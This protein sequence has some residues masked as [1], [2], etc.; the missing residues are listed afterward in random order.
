MTLRYWN[1][2]PLKVLKHFEPKIYRFWTISSLYVWI[3]SWIDLNNL[4]KKIRHF[5][6]ENFLIH[7][8]QSMFHEGR[9]I[10]Q[11]PH[12]VYYSLIT[13]VRRQFA[14]IMSKIIFSQKVILRCLA[15]SKICP[16][17]FLKLKWIYLPDNK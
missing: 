5:L 2:F 7:S 3:L 14:R 12:A 9:Q 17:R 15:K 4:T 8:D 6:F 11:Y 10:F 16:F 1:I 13:F